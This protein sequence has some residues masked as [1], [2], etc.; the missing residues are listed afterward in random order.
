MRAEPKDRMTLRYPI[1]IVVLRCAR[2]GVSRFP[3][4]VEVI[5]LDVWDS[6]LWSDRL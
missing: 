3:I 5:G 1:P 2:G 4:A 6:W